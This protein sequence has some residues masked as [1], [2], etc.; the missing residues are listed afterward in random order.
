MMNA[1]AT[2][3]YKQTQKSDL[4]LICVGHEFVKIIVLKS[5]EIH[6]SYY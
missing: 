5:P 6:G 2:A 1:G 4:D 3:S